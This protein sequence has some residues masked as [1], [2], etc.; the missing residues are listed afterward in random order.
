MRR[1]NYLKQRQTKIAQHNLA[2]SE[3]I[4]RWLSMTVACRYASMSDKTLMGYIKSGNIYGTKKNGKWYIDR[5]S[6]DEFMKSDTVFI[7]DTLTRLK[8]KVTL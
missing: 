7:E 8:G 3:D 6:I 5:L 2:A 1:T 4:V